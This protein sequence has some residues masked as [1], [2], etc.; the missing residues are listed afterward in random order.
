MCSELVEK[1]QSGHKYCPAIVLSHGSRDF[2]VLELQVKPKGRVVFLGSGLSLTSS[3]EQG[4]FSLALVPTM[5]AGRA[6][7]SGSHRGEGAW[8][9]ICCSK[10]M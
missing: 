10:R 8:Q 3:Q 4:V 2:Q 1:K 9:A 6:R 7:A 5:C